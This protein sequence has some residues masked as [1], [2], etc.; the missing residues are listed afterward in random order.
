MNHT[1]QP[2]EQIS[3]RVLRSPF[4][5]QLSFTPPLK[6]TF[7]PSSALNDQWKICSSAIITCQ[8]QWLKHEIF[9]CLCNNFERLGNTCYSSCIPLPC[10]VQRSML[11]EACQLN[12]YCCHYL[13]VRDKSSGQ[14]KDCNKLILLQSSVK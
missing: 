1:R 7:V 13:L 5:L 11:Q 3:S 4:Q 8:Q 10:H 12:Q 14:R 2:A 6:T 9:S